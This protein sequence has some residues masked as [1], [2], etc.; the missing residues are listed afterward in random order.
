MRRL[1]TF[2]MIGFLALLLS[3]ACIS[4]T[5][6]AQA[7]DQSFRVED[8]L[9]VGVFRLVASAD[10]NIANSTGSVFSP[11]IG[12]AS[13]NADGTTIAWSSFSRPVSTVYI[14]DFAGTYV[15]SSQLD[16]SLGELWEFEVAGDRAVFIPA[17]NGIW[18]ADADGAYP[19][20]TLSRDIPKVRDLELTADGSWIYFIADQGAN[21]NDIYAMPAAQ[22]TPQR[23]VDNLNIPCPTV[24][25]CK[26]VWTVGG[27][28]LS[29]DAGTMGAVISGYFVEN[30][31]GDLIGVDHDEVV[32]LS[33]DGYHYITDGKPFGPTI[34]Y[35][36][37]SPDGSTAVFESK[38]S[39]G[40]AG[41][42][43]TRWFATNTGGAGNVAL[44]P[45]QPFNHTVPGLVSDG[46]VVFLDL[47]KLVSTDGETEFALFPSW[48]IRTVAL[49]STNNLM[50]DHTGKRIA[51]TLGNSAFYVGSLNDIDALAHSPIQITDVRFSGGDQAL[52]AVTVTGPVERMSLDA[53]R[54]GVL[55]DQD[56]AAW[57]CSFAPHDDG[58][59]PDV[60]AGDGQFTTTCTS[61]PQVDGAMAFRIGAAT[62]DQG[63]VLVMD[64]PTEVAV[65]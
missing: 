32:V 9:Y 35:L 62:R 40:S 51:F 26:A 6:T 3:L 47:S 54:D 65:E 31:R 28:A 64:V 13:M 29:A 43:A 60:K 20:F 55:L 30:D 4:S 46:S 23:V 57:K 12:H 38:L 14:S 8:L 49:A 21:S 15:K 36:A 50:I 44:L 41:Q 39:D 24:E 10:E 27:L 25:H 58:N 17:T 1:S 53:V 18:A 7:Q 33:G 34:G 42:P 59:A 48:N 11:G 2:T 61:Q 5:V 56:Q 45:E 22:G 19:L 52:L 16:R 63:W 37:L